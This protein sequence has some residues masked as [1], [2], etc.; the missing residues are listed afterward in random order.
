[1]RISEFAAGIGAMLTIGFIAIFCW[2]MGKW[3]SGVPF[4]SPTY[5]RNRAA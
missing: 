5:Q 3:M 2:E 4:R 1:M